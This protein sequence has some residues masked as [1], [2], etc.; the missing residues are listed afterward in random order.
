[1]EK[2]QLKFQGRAMFLDDNNLALI[3]E[4]VV[5]VYDLNESYKE[6]YWVDLTSLSM[7][8]VIQRIPFEDNA[9]DAS[10]AYLYHSDPKAELVKDNAFNRVVYMS[11]FATQYILTTY[12]ENV[13]R[14]WSIKE[15]GMRLTSLCE[16]FQQ[17]VIGISPDTRFVARLSYDT[18]NICIY[19][20]KT[21]LL[22]NTL[23]QNKK[24]LDKKSRKSC[25]AQFCC[26]NY[27]VVCIN[28]WTL[29]DTRQMR[30]SFEIWNV[31]AGKLV[32]QKEIITYDIL[33]RN[34]KLIEPHVIIK[35]TDSHIPEF[36][37]LY[38]T[39][40]SNGSCEIKSVDLNN[41]VPYPIPTGNI[42]QQEDSNTEKQELSKVE[43]HGNSSLKNQKD[44]STGEQEINDNKQRETSNTTQQDGFNISWKTVENELNDFKELTCFRMNYYDG[45][46]LL[47]FG[48]HTV[49]LWRLSTPSTDEQL[50]YIR[51]YK[52]ASEAF[53]QDYDPKWTLNKGWKRD[54]KKVF[55]E[56]LRPDQNG[57]VEVHIC[58]EI[59]LD[60]NYEKTEPISNKYYFD[61]VYLPLEELLQS[62]DNYR[63][64]MD[65]TKDIKLKTVKIQSK[66]SNIKGKPSV[67]S[68]NEESNHT[69]ERDVSVQ[70]SP[71][72]ATPVPSFKFQCV[73]YHY[74]ESACQALHYIW[75]YLQT[76]F[77]L[78]NTRSVEHIF[79]KT[80]NIVET[81]IS[82]MK[83]RKS[84]YF[85]T[86]SGSKTLAMLASF[87]VGRGILLGILETDDLPISLFSY[88]RKNAKT[89][90][91]NKRVTRQE[92]ALTILIE[93]L[94]YDLY[95]LL[96]NRLVFHSRKL[97][98]G[99]FS[100]V[101]DTLIFLQGRGDID[102]LR[103]SLQKLAFL[104]MDQDVRPILTSEAKEKI[105]AVYA[106]F[107]SLDK[108]QV[109]LN[110]IR[111]CAVPF[112][113]FNTY[114]IH[115]E[116][117]KDE[118]VD[119]DKQNSA[120]RKPKSEFLELAL[121]QHENDIFRQGDTVL[122][123]LLQYKWKTF[124]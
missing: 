103:D 91:Y 48:T 93:K 61:E 60:D 63:F 82:E 7:E 113:Y 17:I 79:N 66:A 35:Q 33:N 119:K 45:I 87:E 80:K 122:E 100:A 86:I 68:T 19:H 111:I 104:E 34:Y 83:K 6:K 57:R 90:E 62:E 85:T 8:T 52:P 28:I 12:W 43:Q 110:L 23:A 3:N 120:F 71:L 69:T 18:G 94:E 70:K 41:N 32:L 75:T 38:S 124:A 20:T 44:N 24:G 30:I 108:R 72:P 27:Y 74:I 39:L 51:A 64:S 49:Q 73:E 65:K 50:I 37:I 26:N 84:N 116:D 15:D 112:V 88:S 106:I 11:M 58:S 107:F 89:E 47:R 109:N 96:F 92:N 121:E 118:I 16:S 21:G 4:K 53:T 105:I 123:V 102:I 95:H 46:Y 98:I 13:A 40:S 114:S 78:N 31:N 29:P 14:I 59:F 117:K 101:T 1:M 10:W 9:I 99:S 55:E 2:R 115:P 76:K 36:L 42:E 22:I 67:S 54:E 5:K 56:A 81:T 77:I 25:Y 97:G